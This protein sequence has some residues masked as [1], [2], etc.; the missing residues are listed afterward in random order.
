[1]LS[2]KIFLHETEKSKEIIISEKNF[3]ECRESLLAGM[4][5]SNFTR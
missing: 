3:V 5:I 1:M 4:M 2:V